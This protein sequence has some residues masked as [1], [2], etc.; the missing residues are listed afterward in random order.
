MRL[1][2]KID[3]SFYFYNLSKDISAA[4]GY[5]I[6]TGFRFLNMGWMQVEERDY[7]GSEISFTNGLKYIEPL[8]ENSFSVRLNNGLG[9]SLNLM[10]RYEEG[11]KY[12][13]KAIELNKNN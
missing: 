4:I 2:Y 5:S 7:L 10:D 3:S 11:R 8:N 13:Y 6:Q 12:Y 1:E 9:Y